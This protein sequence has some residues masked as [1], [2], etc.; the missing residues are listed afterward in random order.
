[1]PFSASTKRED[2]IFLYFAQSRN[3]LGMGLKAFLCQ[4]KVKN[5]FYEIKRLLLTFF[6]FS[7]PN[8]HENLFLRTLLLFKN[9]GN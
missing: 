5:F 9:F 1:M 2:Y 4:N 3:F 8:K 7:T 6:Q